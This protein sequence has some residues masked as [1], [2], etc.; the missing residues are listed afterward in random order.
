MTH[1]SYT[2]RLMTL[3]LSVTL[4]LRRTSRVNKTVV[5]PRQ[6]AARVVTHPSVPRAGQKAQEDFLLVVTVVKDTAPR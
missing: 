4:P 3:G 5:L 1:A 6:E 2:C